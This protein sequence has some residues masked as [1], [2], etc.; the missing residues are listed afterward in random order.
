MGPKRGGR[1]SVQQSPQS[2]EQIANKNQTG[3]WANTLIIR[4]PIVILVVLVILLVE[5]IVLV[6]VVVEVGVIEVI[7][8]IV[9]VVGNMK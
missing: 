3:A 2:K 1:K 7:L 9:V 5:V 6:V 8:V 4:M